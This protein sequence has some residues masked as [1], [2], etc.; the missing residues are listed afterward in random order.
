MLSVQ[1]KPRIAVLRETVATMLIQTPGMAIRNSVYDEYDV[2][3][4]CTGLGSVGW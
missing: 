4:K 2:T 1:G 3:V